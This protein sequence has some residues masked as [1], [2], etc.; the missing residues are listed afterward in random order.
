[1]TSSAQALVLAVDDDPSI[2]K[3]LRYEL[4]GQ[5]LQVITAASGEETL[6]LADEQHPDLIVLDV[7][8]PDISGLE[9]MRRLRERST[10]PIV[11]LT[12]KGAD[13]DKVRGLLQGADDYL[14]KPFNPE[15]LSAR[16]YAILRRARRGNGTSGR[17]IA[18]DGLEIDLDRR[19]VRRAGR[20]IALTRTEW[21]LLQQLA[22][23]AGKVL[24]SAEILSKVWG[25]EYRDDLQ[26][27]RVWISRLRSKLERDD[28]RPLI[29]TFRGVGYMF[30]TA[31][32]GDE[33][34]EPPARRAADPPRGRR[35]PE[36]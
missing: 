18:V 27:L 10:T 4:A 16:V 32:A 8:L 36:R 13:A 25:P 33:P 19:I 14:T 35:A 21:N 20:L 29:K 7:M 30:D 6:R 1:M 15:E 5:G 2:L 17:V 24:A 22:G 31:A 12:G 11:L 9:V 28:A 34:P 26:Y 23:N 3:L